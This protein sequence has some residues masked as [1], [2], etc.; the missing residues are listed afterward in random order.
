MRPNL[1]IFDELERKGSYANL[2]LKGELFISPRLFL[3]ET[4]IHIFDAFEQHIR[5]HNTERMLLD[6]KNDVKV[7]LLQRIDKADSLRFESLA[8]CSKA[9]PDKTDKELFKPDDSWVDSATFKE[10]IAASLDTLV[11]LVPRDDYVNEYVSFFK[12][13]KEYIH[14]RDQIISDIHN[15]A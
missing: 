3:L 8:T 6:C 2:I 5:A 1:D 9:F 15:R 4:L 14:L 10:K 7:M 13:N 12:D 11:A